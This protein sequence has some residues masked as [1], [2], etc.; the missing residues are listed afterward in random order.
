MNIYWRLVQAD[1]SRLKPHLFAYGFLSMGT[2]AMMAMPWE[3]VVQVA[4]VLTIF[5]MVGFY[6]HLVMKAV[7]LERKEKNHLFLMTLPVSVRQLTVAKITSVALMFSVVWTPSFVLVSIL[8]NLNPHWSSAAPAFYTLAF[9]A[10]LPAFALIL[11]V[12]VLTLSEGATILAFTFANMLVALLL[13]LVPQSDA[14]QEAFSRGTIDEV[15]MA[16][17]EQ[18]VMFIL[19]NLL[20]FISLLALCYG[21]ALRKSSF[22]D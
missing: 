12:A 17:P 6:C 13:N 15:G 16:W 8:G 19:A 3:T 4:A 11:S 21:A 1:F 20:M 18:A 10:Y 7:I 22:S 9:T 2:T 14:M 5:V